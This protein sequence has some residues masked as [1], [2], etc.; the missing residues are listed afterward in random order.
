MSRCAA[1]C[2]F[3]N[4]SPRAVPPNRLAVPRSPYGAP[5]RCD[6]LCCHFPPLPTLVRL[7]PWMLFTRLPPLMLVLRLKLLFMLTSMS[8][9]PQPQPQPQP[10]SEEHTSEIPRHCY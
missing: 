2:R 6:G 1:R 8:P 9:P 3:P 7:P 10:R 4:E 5:P